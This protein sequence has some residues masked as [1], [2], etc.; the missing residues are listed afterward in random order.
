MGNLNKLLFKTIIT[1]NCILLPILIISQNYT[2]SKLQKIQY[3]VTNKKH[4]KKAVVE[5]NVIRSIKSYMNK[6]NQEINEIIF[7][8]IKNQTLYHIKKEIIL[9]SYIISSSKYGTGNRNGSHKTPTGLHKIKEKH[10]ENTPIN[11]RM[12]GRIYTGEIAKIYTDTT[13]SKTDDI[14]S[15]ILWLEGLETKKNKGH[16]IDSFSRYIYIHGTS[17]E[18]RLGIPSSQG[19]IRMKN[20]DVIDLYNKVAIGTLVLIL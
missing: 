16:N 15:R 13:Q 20:K 18:G 11:G 6:Y 7:V 10:G 17:E 5:R 9:N 14:T 8:S 2:K 4:K 19:C 1:L 12:I 3:D